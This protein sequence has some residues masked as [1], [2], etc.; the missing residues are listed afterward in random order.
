MPLLALYEPGQEYAGG[1]RF[2]MM[3]GP[4]RVFCW[5]SREALDSV[6]DCPPEERRARFERYRL[7]IEQAAR[8][9]YI[10]GEQSPIVMSFDLG[11]MR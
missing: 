4:T 9:K 8:E 5:V 2:T 3:D 11:T 6:C 10:A 1:V 7:R